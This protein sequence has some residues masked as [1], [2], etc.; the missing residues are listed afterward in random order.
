M[1]KTDRQQS[2]KRGEEIAERFLLDKGYEILERNF[3]HKR[4]EIDLIALWENNVLVFVEV[5]HRKGNSFGEPESFVSDNQQKSILDASE[6]YLY[7]I[8]WKKDVRFDII[9]INAGDEINHFK[10]AFY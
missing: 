10:D 5:K 1:T 7:A 8:N 2:G 4:A 6:S 3:R 9:S